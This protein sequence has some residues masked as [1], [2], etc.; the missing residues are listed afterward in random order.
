MHHI[1]NQKPLIGGSS[2]T[3]LWLLLASCPKI[4]AGGVDLQMILCDSL[5]V[6]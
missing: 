6:V 2:R 3:P 1:N 4:L 5:N